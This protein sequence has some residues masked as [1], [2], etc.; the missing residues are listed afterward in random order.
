ML[1]PD[2]WQFLD[3]NEKHKYNAFLKKFLTGPGLDLLFYLL[4]GEIFFLCYLLDHVLHHLLVAAL[5]L[6]YF[7]VAALLHYYLLSAT[8]LLHYELVEGALLLLGSPWLLYSQSWLGD[9][10]QRAS[11]R[12]CFKPIQSIPS[13]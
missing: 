5:L 3:Q 13:T 6:H 10:Y 1:N 12:R 9:Y 2:I 8:L 7:V 4:P 11:G